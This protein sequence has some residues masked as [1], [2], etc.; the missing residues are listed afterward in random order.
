[1]GAP[2][3]AGPAL[4]DEIDEL[5]RQN[6]RH[7]DAGVEQ[8]LVCLRHEAFDHLD[9]RPGRDTWPPRLADPFPDVV[10]AP[11]EITRA[12]VSAATVCGGLVN[13]GCTLV[14][15]LFDR[16]D[17]EQLARDVDRAFDAF[18]AWVADPSATG[19]WFTPFEPGPTY[20]RFPPVRR[21]WIRQAGG[22][23]VADSPRLLFDVLDLL[24]SAGMLEII[25]EYLGE[26]PV[27]SVDKSTLRR[28]TP[29]KE[30]SWHQDGSFLGEGV[31]TVNTWVALSPCG[32]DADA[33]GLELIPRRF[34]ALAPA[35]TPGAKVRIE[36]AP[37]EVARA[38]AGAPVLRPVFEPGDALVFD[39]L[40]LHRTATSPGMTGVRY[41]LESWFFAPS[42]FPTD[43]FPLTC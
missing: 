40:F 9:R 5:S 42:S 13:H 14:R 8:R 29:D 32:G 27:L 11:P 7:R 4:L 20:P 6:R 26:P 34:E 28:V 30:P 17:A 1:V 10:D 36:V 35:G 21:Q 2:A 3:Q 37:D 33:P 39:E 25:A 18:D 16:A 38:A 15:G 22:V 41:A 31:R 23:L 24:G 43:Y 19:S 12:E